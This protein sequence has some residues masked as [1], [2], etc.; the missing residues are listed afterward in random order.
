MILQRVVDAML[1]FVHKA[2]GV[3]L[4]VIEDVLR[5]SGLDRFIAASPSALG[6]RATTMEKIIFEYEATEISR[7]SKNMPS[8]KLSVMEDETWLGKMHLVGM[9]AVSG[10]I[11]VE[12]PAERRDGESWNLAMSHGIEGFPVKIIQVTSDEGKGLIHH[13]KAI[14]GAHHSPD[15]F[16]IQ[17]EISRGMAAALAAQVR[18]AE[19]SVKEALAAVEIARKEQ[20]NDAKKER[21]SGRPIDWEKRL[22]TSREVLQEAKQKLRQTEERQSLFRATIRGI[23][24]DYHPIS[25][26]AGV[27]RTTR[28][29]ERCLNERFSILKDLIKMAD[30]PEYSSRALAKAERVL[31][32]MVATASFVLGEWERFLANLGLSFKEVWQIRAR[33]L[34]A[35]YLERL[36][37]KKKKTEEKSML[38]KVA[39][40][41]EL[42]FAPESPLHS[43]TSEE[44]SEILKKCREQVSLFQRSSSPLEGRNGRLSQIHASGRG[45]GERTLHALTVIANFLIER[46]DGTTAAERFFGTC[47]RKMTEWIFSRMPLYAASRKS[48]LAPMTESLGVLVH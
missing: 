25:I 9:D 17:R 31:P 23:S 33:L 41:I 26:D 20:E 12:K 7:L 24:D 16:H 35:I 47:P 28:D 43:W 5:A 42:A 1:L 2:A 6:Q 13:A 4:R 37:N 44:R 32:S 40:N 21:S 45:L 48:A 11:L 39:K 30:L 10:Y 36:A 29:V 14:L 19:K 34:P 46:P 3:G 27:I 38:K 8:R 22:M 15:L 18:G